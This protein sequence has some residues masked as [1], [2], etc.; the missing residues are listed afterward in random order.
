MG[1]HQGRVVVE[2][3][4][5]LTDL[6]K[7]AYCTV[8]ELAKSAR[9]DRT[10]E[11]GAGLGLSSLSGNNWI[12]SDVEGA[13]PLSLLNYAEALDRKSTR[14]NSSHVSESRM[15]SSA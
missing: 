10:I 1:D 13:E 3:D 12:K 6:Y 7:L 8:S 4:R 9:P 11:V 2:G 5:Y 15:P 14:L